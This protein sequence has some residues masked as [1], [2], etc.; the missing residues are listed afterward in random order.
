MDLRVVFWK[1][2][3][4]VGS[5]MANRREFREVMGHVF[6]GRLEPVV[7]VVWP[8]SRVAD[9]HRRLEQGEA[10]GKVVLLP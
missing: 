8:L 5:T 9:A 7:D 1:Q 10:V 6:A 2:I 3:E 4:I